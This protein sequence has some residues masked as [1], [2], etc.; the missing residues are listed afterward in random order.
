MGHFPS[1]AI[2]LMEQATKTLKNSAGRIRLKTVEVLSSLGILTED[3]QGVG[4]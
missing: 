1:C 4:R 3:F 2:A